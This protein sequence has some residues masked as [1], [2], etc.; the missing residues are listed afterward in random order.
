MIRFNPRA[1]VGRDH[2]AHATG[3]G[4]RAVSIHAPAW[5]ATGRCSPAARRR[6]CFNP[7]ARVGRD[8]RTFD[9]STGFTSF[10][11]RARVGRDQQAPTIEV[12]ERMFQSTRPRGARLA[13]E[14]GRLHDIGFQSTRPRGARHTTEC[15]SDVYLSVSIHAPAWGATRSPRW[16]LMTDI[17]FNPRARVGRDS[18]REGDVQGR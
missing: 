13:L 14:G 4:L 7:R 8:A 18:N 1:R 15:R 10:N 6:K 3:A 12:P 17:C 2:P 16:G 11:P 9:I 5:G